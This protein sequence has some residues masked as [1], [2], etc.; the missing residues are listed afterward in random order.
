MK[1]KQRTLRERN[2]IFPRA[3]ERIMGLFDLLDLKRLVFKDQNQMNIKL[4]NMEQIIVFL[5]P[6][7]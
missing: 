7:D 5:N 2:E 3:W 4:K 1:Q 6:L